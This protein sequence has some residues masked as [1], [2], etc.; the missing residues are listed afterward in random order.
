M[1]RKPTPP[2]DRKFEEMQKGKT[3]WHPG[4][5]HPMDTLAEELSQLRERIP[6]QLEQLRA[7]AQQTEQR[8]RAIL[9]AMPNATDDPTAL[10]APAEHAAVATTTLRFH[11]RKHLGHL[12]TIFQ[13]QRAGRTLGR[14]QAI[15]A[16]L[17]LA[18]GLLE[19]EEA[20]SAESLAT[21]RTFLQDQEEDTSAATTEPSPEQLQLSREELR[22]QR[23]NEPL[24]PIVGSV[25][26]SRQLL[27][28]FEARLPELR[29]QL[30]ARQGWFEVFSVPKRRFKREVIAYARALHA[31][32]KKKIPLPAEVEQA[33]HPEVRRL[34]QARVESFPPALRD[35]VYNTV[36][37]GPYV[38]Y[39]WTEAKQNYSISLGL[40]DD[41][42]P[43]PFVPEGF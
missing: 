29:R 20:F 40:R 23:I 27:R 8:L 30:T 16:A 35:E 22:L 21:W 31:Y 15:A 14:L 9:E 5:D 41:Y 39:R 36:S 25:E 42:P 18:N 43:F 7:S 6:G 37:V 17:D 1:P 32:Q 28:D 2:G 26:Q 11:N 13:I 4:E 33:V 3:S 19:E 34:I 10:F 24:T 12:L 38:K